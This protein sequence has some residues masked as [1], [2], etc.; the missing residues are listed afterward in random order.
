M[1][2]KCSIWSTPTGRRTAF[3]LQADPVLA[4]TAKDEADAEAANGQQGHYTF[5]HIY[6]SLRSYGY[7]HPLGGVG[8]NAAGAP[9][10]W[11]DA[12]SVVQAWIN[13]PNHRANILGNFTYSGVGLTVANGTYWWAQDFAS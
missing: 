12:Q 3:T 7:S 5:G 8:E 13:E 4:H 11:T 6:D 9:G 2:S 10:F 1:S